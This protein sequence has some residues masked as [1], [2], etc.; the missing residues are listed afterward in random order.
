MTASR[1]TFTS[2]QVFRAGFWTA[3]GLGLR[4]FIGLGFTL[5]LVRLLTP[6]D[7]GTFAIVSAVYFLGDTLVQA[8]TRY[9]TLQSPRIN[10]RLL[11]AV[12]SRNHATALCG[13]GILLAYGSFQAVI[14]GEAIV[15]IV[16]LG[17]CMTLTIRRFSAINYFLYL[18]NLDERRIS[19]TESIAE[20]ISLSV[21]VIVA[22]V[23]RNAIALAAGPVI[24]SLVVLIGTWMARNYPAGKPTSLYAGYVTRKLNYIV[25]QSLTSQ[26]YRIGEANLWVHA[27]SRDALGLLNVSRNF[28][29]KIRD[30]S[31]PKFANTILRVM[32]SVSHDRKKTEQFSNAVTFVFVAAGIPLVVFVG[33]YAVEATLFFLGGNWALAAPFLFITILTAFCMNTGSSL[34]SV[35]AATGNT[36]VIFVLAVSRFGLQF[37][38]MVVLLPF[39]IDAILLGLLI[40]SG[41]K[42]A[43]DLIVARRLTGIKLWRTFGMIGGTYC[44]LA[45]YMNVIGLSMIDLSNPIQK[46]ALVVASCLGLQI[47]HAIVFRKETLFWWVRLRK[48]LIAVL[49]RMHLGKLAKRIPGSPA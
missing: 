15:A 25:G 4:R 26:L 16:S 14:L 13:V 6:D 5:I 21:T 28:S 3:I 46:G 43:V 41:L 17:F 12:D 40:F 11:H 19:I 29:R 47:I 37:L 49:E 44:A 48:S 34:M 31:S 24:Q 1:D 2:G 38:M 42:I 8:P 20:F 23:L 36:K 39:G 35:L 7:Y 18:R 30:V 22:L 32:S 9:L 27:F 45:I 10:K 33:P